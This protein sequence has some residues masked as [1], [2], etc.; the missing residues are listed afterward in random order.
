[1]TNKNRP[2][3]SSKGVDP[4]LITSLYEI[5]TAINALMEVDEIAAIIIDHCLKR[6]DAEQGMVYLL[7]K[8]DDKS[9]QF[10]TFLRGFARE[11]DK[12]PFHINQ[13]LAALILKNRSVILCNDPDSDRLFKSLNLTG[14]G[15][16]SLLSAPLITRQ[17][18]IGILVLVNNRTDDGFTDHDKRF[19][20][21]V[22]T[23]V[24]KVV[25]AAR[26]HEEEKQ[27]IALKEELNIAH[28][29]QKKFLPSSGL[30]NEKC[31]V[32]GLNIPA[33]DLGGDFFDIVQMSEQSVFVSLGDVMGKGIPA[34]LI[35]SNAMAVLRSQLSRAGKFF[36][37]DIADSLNNMVHMFTPSGQFIT[38]VFGEYVCRN[39]SF[40]Y[41]N[42]GHPPLIIV[43]AS[44][45][46]ESPSEE[47]NDIAVGILPDVQFSINRVN[48]DSGDML[49]I[50]SDGITECFNEADE[51]F[52]EE[53]LKSFLKY[54][55]TKS[56]A[57]IAR[58]LPLELD[59][60]RGKNERSDDITLLLIQSK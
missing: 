42:A 19:L 8:S 50:Y 59:K 24:A 26:L 43:R 38:T 55:H 47:E 35:M 5:S 57:E 44:G 17:G 31:T 1:M 21:I 10:K 12:I 2:A 16:K 54:N 32:V 23:Q 29:I 18:M 4:E 58:L 27:L 25:E 3:K 9:D 13:S 52:G 46:I 60:F 51:E 56:A 11:T 7:D 34:A 33:K 15:I 37:A 49:F 28:H 41:I 6:I 14:Y 36:L 22:G 20:G 53:R 45:E 48:L 39:K 40:N 30:D